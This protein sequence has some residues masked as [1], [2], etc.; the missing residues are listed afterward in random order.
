[1]KFP[2]IFIYGKDAILLKYYDCGHDQAIVNIILLKFLDI[3]P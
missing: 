1:M 2:N 3:P